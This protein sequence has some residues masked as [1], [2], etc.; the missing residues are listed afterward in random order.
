MRFSSL[1][2]GSS[3]NATFI[4]SG[5]TRI[6]LDQGLPV[7]TLVSRLTSIGESLSDLTAIVVSHGH[8]D[9]V[10]GLARTVRAG[11]SRGRA[12]PAYLTPATA[13]LIDWEGLQR[14]PVSYF[15]AGSKFEIGDLQIQSFSVSHDCQD[16]VAFTVTDR[17]GAKS[18]VAVDLGW[19]PDAMNWYAKGSQIVLVESNYDSELLRSGAYPQPV[20]D[21][22]SGETG[23]LSNAATRN[24]IRR[25]MPESVQHLLLGHLSRHNNIPYLVSEGAAECLASRGLSNCS[26]L[27]ATHQEATRIIEI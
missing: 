3:G 14:P 13:D 2:S 20:K 1:S 18:C 24:W 5:D 19:I 8:G 10:S 16:P 27:I 7:K 23:H 15:E 25:D 17:F 4:S 22:I 6:L 9:H 21:R 26:L 12:I 11:I